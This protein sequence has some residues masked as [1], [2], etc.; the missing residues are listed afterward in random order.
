MK[1]APFLNLVLSLV[2]VVALVW[3]LFVGRH[4]LLP[5]V[6]AVISVYVMG[7][8]SE[9]LSRLPL[10][11]Y[12][13]KAMLR[14]LTLMIFVMVGLIIAIVVTST[15]GDIAAVAPGYEATFDAMVERFANRFDLD[16]QE[17]WADAH[18]AT[19]GR[20]DFQSA[21]LA[22]LGG[23]TSLSSKLFLVIVYAAFLMGERESFS[24]KIAAAARDEYQA[25]M[26]LRIIGD[27][28]LK[29][30]KYLTVKTLIN[31]ILGAF[32]YVILEVIGVDF[33]L[34][35]AIAIALLNYIP[36]VGSLLGVLLPVALSLAQ[37]GSFA[38]T[39][40]LATLLIGAQTYV[41]NVLEPRMIGRQLNLSPFVV[42]AALSFWTALWGV[43]GAI[44]A[45]PMTSM[46]AIVL[47]GFES[48]RFL[49]ILL[50][51]RID[52][53]SEAGI[54]SKGAP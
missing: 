21:F 36:Y 42:L 13:P 10:L 5:I 20:I 26:T 51:E 24:Q 9:A 18:A 43:P 12:F 14:L 31:L 3:I 52:E 44:L 53:P 2:F 41:G 15:V 54:H 30:R 50:A 16:A 45:I 34:F 4:L 39:L 6:T 38:T 37:F 49:A 35:W 23:F 48:T 46:V 11:R 29:I 22:L 32:S 28:N 40:I 1:N 33:A 8:A 7:A 25:K 17:L 47:A 19:V 27:I